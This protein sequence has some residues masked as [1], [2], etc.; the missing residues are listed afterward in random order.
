MPAFPT[1]LPA[2]HTPDPMAAPALRWGILGTGWIAERFARSV[3]RHTRQSLTAVASRDRG[4]AEDFARRHGIPR[5][6]GSYEGLT[7]ASDID[8]VY[9]ATEHTAHL[10]CA[11]LALEHGKHVL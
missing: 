10:T 1:A 2:A 6:H 5:A 11:R 7:A 9:V 4:R 8:V 3:Q